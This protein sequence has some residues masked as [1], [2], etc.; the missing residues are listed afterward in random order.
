VLTLA[1]NVAALGPL[2]LLARGL[3]RALGP[4]RGPSPADP[5]GPTVARADPSPTVSKSTH[6]PG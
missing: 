5:A 3:G 1:L 2:F 4:S 6:P